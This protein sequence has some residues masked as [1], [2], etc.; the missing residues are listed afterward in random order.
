LRI[1]AELKKY[2]SVLRLARLHFLAPGIMQYFL[3]YFLALLGGVDYDLTKFVFGYLIFGTAH[4]SVSFSNDYF[5][6]RSDRNSVRTAFSGGSKVLVEQPDMESFALKFAV[7]LLFSSTIANI[8]FTVIYGYTF[9]FFIFGLI[10]GLLGWFYTAPPLKL[11]YRG[12]GE[13]STM[14]AVGV[15]MPG[16]GY[17]VAS[18]TLD[19]LFQLLILPLSCYGLFF[20]ITVEFPDVESDILGQKKNLLVKY[21]RNA[22]KIVSVAATLMGTLLLILLFLLG[23]PEEIVDWRPFVIF[24]FVPLFTSIFTGLYNI[25]TRK[26]VVRTVMFNMASMILFLFMMNVSLMIQIIS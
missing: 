6:I 1:E 24:S 11:S 20:I 16:M 17:F 2:R 9:W 22:G 7:F 19:S 26:F 3:G 14:L 23:I 12:L 15:F 13:L 8:I 5:D 21:G 4:L 18:G 10:G 25:N